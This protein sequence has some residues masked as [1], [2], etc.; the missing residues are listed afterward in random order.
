MDFELQKG[1]ETVNPGT[2]VK[3]L[4]GAANASAV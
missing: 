4:A 1:G 2:Y 3:W